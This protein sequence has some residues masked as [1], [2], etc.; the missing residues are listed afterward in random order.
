[1]LENL[2]AIVRTCALCA[3]S[4]FAFHLGCTSKQVSVP[5]AHAEAEVLLRMVQRIFFD[6]G[7]KDVGEIVVRRDGSYE[8]TV[9]YPSKLAFVPK[10]FEGNLPPSLMRALQADVSQKSGFEVVEGVPTYQYGIENHR[11]DHPAGIEQLLNF[12]RSNGGGG[13]Y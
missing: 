7:W 5:A 4:A 3:I 6:G 12:V 11:V 1:M 9:D 2:S 8:R 10:A 13:W